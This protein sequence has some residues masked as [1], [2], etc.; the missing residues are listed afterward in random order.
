MTGRKGM[1]LDASLIERTRF[2]QEPA[3]CI[4]AQLAADFAV[5]IAQTPEYRRALN[6]P[7]AVAIP[8]ERSAILHRV[9][10]P[11][12]EGWSVLEMRWDVSL[13]NPGEYSSISAYLLDSGEVL[14]VVNARDR[15]TMLTRRIT[16][17]QFALLFLR[18]WVQRDSAAA[19]TDADDM[20]DALQGV[21]ERVFREHIVPEKCI[22]DAGLSKA[23]LALIR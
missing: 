13:Y 3:S 8:A 7:R 18:A 17:E 4:S 10:Q 9:R 21:C 19:Y 15:E 16:A 20:N 5:R 23:L 22:A 12:V 11:A 6:R 2:E 1:P 14:C